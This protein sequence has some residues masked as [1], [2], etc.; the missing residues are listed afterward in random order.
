MKGSDHD[1]NKFDNVLDNNLNTRWSNYGKSSYLILDLGSIENINVVD[2]SWFK[3]N[4]RQYF[5][6]ISVSVKGDDFLTST[7]DFPTIVYTG[8][9]DGKS[10]AP[11]R[12]KFESKFNARYVNIRVDG[13]SQNNWAS[14]TEIRL[15]GQ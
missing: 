6:E 3:G 15:Y 12:Y 11:Q 1:G 2:I 13:N 14:V 9:S 5:F 7:N 8:I 10:L 4:K